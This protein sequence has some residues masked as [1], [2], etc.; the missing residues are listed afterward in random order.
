MSQ[1]NKIL[2]GLLAAQLALAALTWTSMASRP[3]SSGS[4]PVFS[5]DA[6]K[7]VAL[8]V[9][10]RPKS[11]SDKEETV[12]LAKKG[13]QWVV[14]DRDDFPADREKVR[15][16]LDQLVKLKIGVALASNPANHNALKVGERDYD[17]V[18][19][20]ETA[21]DE[22]TVIVGSGPASSVNLRYKGKNEVYRARGISV[23]AINGSVRGYVDT[24][25]VEADKDK[26]SQVV[27]SNER[28]RLS[29]AKQ[30]EKWVLA[31][32]PAGETLDENKVKTFINKM[33]TLNLQEP[34]GKELKAEY[35]LTGGAEVFLVG[36]GDEG[37]VTTRY[38]IGAKRDAQSLYAKADDNDW[39][40]AVSKWSAEDIRNKGPADF[41]K[42]AEKK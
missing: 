7:V 38:V 27:V 39:V 29:F 5:F 8:R 15:K 21:K 13:D 31:E 9:K 35:G 37:T 19:T 23:W 25:Y 3:A 33:T 34:M 11:G 10:A 22:A 26:L 41:V 24:K 40:V 20:L 2:V 4:R 14:A 1:M 18:V 42:P 36:S 12:R 28:G 16:V 30:G 32:L 17:R 6:D